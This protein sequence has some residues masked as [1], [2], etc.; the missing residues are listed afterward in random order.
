MDRKTRLA[1]GYA[2][3]HFLLIEHGKTE[4]AHKIEDIM[5]ASIRTLGFVWS[6]E[7]ADRSLDT[8]FD[9]IKREIAT[10][11]AEALGTDRDTILKAMT[12]Q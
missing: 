9:I 10:V 11:T 1:I 2:H 6:T 4:A 8:M 7:N 3:C 5:L 12:R